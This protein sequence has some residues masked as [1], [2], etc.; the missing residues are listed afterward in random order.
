MANYYS[1]HCNECEVKEGYDSPD[2]FRYWEDIEIMLT[3]WDAFHGVLELNKKIRFHEVGFTIFGIGESLSSFLE[4]HYNEG[5][6]VNLSGVGVDK[7][8]KYTKAQYANPNP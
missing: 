1:L 8:F 4:Y 5:H 6:E 3:N 7:N 2:S